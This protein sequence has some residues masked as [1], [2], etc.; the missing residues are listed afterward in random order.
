M[1]ENVDILQVVSTFLFLVLTFRFPNVYGRASAKHVTPSRGL[2]LSAT[3]GCTEQLCGF[4]PSELSPVLIIN[5][6]EINKKIHSIVYMYKN[7]NCNRIFNKGTTADV[8]G[9]TT[10]QSRAPKVTPII[11]E[12][13]RLLCSILS[14]PFCYCIPCTSSICGF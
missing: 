9:E 5:A 14:F 13:Y 8:T 3:R 1:D 12:E 4:E 10:C 6:K 11:S 7:Y 2:P